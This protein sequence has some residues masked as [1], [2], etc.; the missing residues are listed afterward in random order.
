LAH[1]PDITN[2]W[3]GKDAD[4]SEI[5]D[6]FVTSYNEGTTTCTVYKAGYYTLS[7]SSLLNRKI[8]NGPVLNICKITEPVQAPEITASY[9]GTRSSKPSGEETFDSWA[10]SDTTS[11]EW[12]DKDNIPEIL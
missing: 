8:E 2:I 12:A 6:D 3:T 1:N 10:Q 4:G 7:T 11:E 9:Y 5:T